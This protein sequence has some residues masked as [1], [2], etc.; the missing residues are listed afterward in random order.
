LAARFGIEHPNNNGVCQV[1]HS[2]DD[3]ELPS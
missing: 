1:Q 3:V 2:P